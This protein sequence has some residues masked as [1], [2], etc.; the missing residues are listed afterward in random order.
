MCI[1]SDTMVLVAYR[2]LLLIYWNYPKYL[3]AAAFAIN[4]FVPDPIPY[5]DEVIM[6]AGLLASDR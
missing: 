1:K 5:I 2:I 4:F 6:V 3:K